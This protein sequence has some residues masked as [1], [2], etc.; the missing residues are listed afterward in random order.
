M[1]I[2]AGVVA[3]VL[4]LALLG[5]V[6]VWWTCYRTP[7]QPVPITTSAGGGA[8]IT[9]VTNPAEGEIPIA[10]GAPIVA[11]ADIDCQQTSPVSGG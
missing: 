11:R 6:V 5:W 10:T 3:G 9:I 8:A 4:V 7:S 2:I 1:G